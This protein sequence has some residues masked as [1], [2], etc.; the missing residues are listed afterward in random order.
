MLSFLLGMGDLR[1]NFN[2]TVQWSAIQHFGTTHILGRKY[3]TKI[4]SK[5]MKN[6]E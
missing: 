5:K 3:K 1:E 4:S 2:P 6:I